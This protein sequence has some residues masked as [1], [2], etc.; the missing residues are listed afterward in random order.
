MPSS[1]PPLFLQFYLSTSCKHSFYS[2]HF[3][4]NFHP[5]IS[6]SSFSDPLHFL[7][8]INFSNLL[9]QQSH[10]WQNKILQFC[11]PPPPLRVF[12]TKIHLSFIWFVWQDQ[13]LSEYLLQII[14]WRIISK[15]CM[16]TFFSRLHAVRA[17]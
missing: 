5:S 6:T 4:P 8:V 1:F 11:F 14:S 16:R 2:H 3:V 7:A 13:F 10:Y 12:A 15:L 17:L 9:P